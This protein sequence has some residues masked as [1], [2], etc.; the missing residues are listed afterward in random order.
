MSDMATDSPKSHQDGTQ[1]TPD[2]GVAGEWFV[3]CNSYHYPIAIIDS[4]ILSHSQAQIS[5]VCTRNTFFLPLLPSALPISL[6]W[7]T[8]VTGPL[9]THPFPSS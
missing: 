8:T 3:H 7:V 1:T 5:G 4:S 9:Y 6:L 2:S